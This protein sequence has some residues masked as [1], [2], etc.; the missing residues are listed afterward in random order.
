MVPQMVLSRACLIVSAMDDNG[1]GWALRAE[2][3]PALYIIFLRV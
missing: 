1:K 2:A 3:G